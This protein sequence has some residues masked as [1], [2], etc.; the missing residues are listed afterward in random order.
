M[1]TAVKDIY[2]VL[3]T[4]L[5][6]LRRNWRRVLASS[7]VS[8]ILYLAAFGW[9]LG[10]NISMD[11]TKYLDFVIPGI[12]AMTSMNSS[13]S[14]AGMKLNVDRLFYGCFD[15]YLISPV[16][17]YSLIIG[18]AM[19]GVVRG[20]ISSAAFLILGFIISRALIISPLF[21]LSLIVACFTFA[22]LGELAALVAKS[23]QDMSTF[24]SL[25]VL[26]MAF[27]GGTFFAI[28]QLPS[29]LKTVIYCLPLT[30][31]CSCL[32]AEAL[33]SHF[34][35]IS[36]LVLAC[37]GAAFFLGCALVLRKSSV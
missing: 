1:L 14:G 24:N 7:L 18:K 30:H 35:W 33:G 8:P 34:P 20:F 25:V 31:S 16:N 37:F 5:R 15:E 10:R 12:I 26:P 22:F 11:G 2:S 29:W 23:H 4:D 19:I 27:L 6:V 17:F 3:W 32:R 36:L 13:F 21:I 9:G 28:D